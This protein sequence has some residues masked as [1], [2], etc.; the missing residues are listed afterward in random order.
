MG[1]LIRTDI[2]GAK[3]MGMKT[4]WMQT[5]GKTAPDHTQPDYTITRLNQLLSIPELN[6]S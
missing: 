1:D 5:E 3:A 4:V 6:S 2:A